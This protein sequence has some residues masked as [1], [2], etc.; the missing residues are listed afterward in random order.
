MADDD[1]R[2]GLD[3]PPHVQKPGRSRGLIA[4][5]MNNPPP[6]L[7]ADDLLLAN[8]ERLLH[9][10]DLLS[11]MVDELSQ[12]AASSDEASSPSEYTADL[13]LQLAKSIQHDATNSDLSPVSIG[14]RLLVAGYL[15][16]KLTMPTKESHAEAS[17]HLI[18]DIR[19]QTA[20][21][22][23]DAERERG[24]QWMR[25]RAHEIWEQ[26]HTRGL[27]VGEVA[28]MVRDDVVNETEK[29]QAQGD[30]GPRKHWPRSLNKIRKVIREV[31]PDS[32]A[33]PGRPSKK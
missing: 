8:A 16:G 29:R 32:A 20:F 25:R 12:M 17:K 9:G 23:R 1:Q 13:C 24:Y 26:D 18:A 7:M 10:R 3:I 30:D 2:F 31:A 33:K 15:F 5:A 6:K 28:N 22:D 19:R 4:G 14:H 27:R 21:R 11:Q